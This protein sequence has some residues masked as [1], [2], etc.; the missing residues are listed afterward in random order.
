L[1]GCVPV[2]RVD[3]RTAVD[4]RMQWAGPHPTI[5]AMSADR[6]SAH[7]DSVSTEPRVL[8]QGL[9]ADLMSSWVVDAVRLRL[10]GLQLSRSGGRAG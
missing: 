10:D 5:F 3:R 2:W 7:L 1:P 9:A 4:E 6:E 8:P